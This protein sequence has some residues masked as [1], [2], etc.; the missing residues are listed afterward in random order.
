MRYFVI[1]IQNLA[2]EEVKDDSWFSNPIKKIGRKN[3]LMCYFDDFGGYT[4]KYSWA[5]KKHYYAK[6]FVW[7]KQS[8]FSFKGWTFPSEISNATNSSSRNGRTF[9][10]FSFKCTRPN[11][12]SLYVGVRVDRSYIWGILKAY[13][14]LINLS[15]ESF[16]SN[17]YTINNERH[18]NLDS[19]YYYYSDCC[20]KV[21]I[22]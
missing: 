13:A 4:A 22:H 17:S 16:N 10:E 1:N 6:F 14:T 18:I 9:N 5:S 19:Y 11:G 8:S 7:G 15:E 2:V 20:K 3:A 21:Y 12:E